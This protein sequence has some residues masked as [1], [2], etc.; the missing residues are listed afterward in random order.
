MQVTG[1]SF[2]A[3]DPDLMFVHGLDYEVFIFVRVAILVGILS[4]ELV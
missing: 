3:V 1:L 4:M 2:S